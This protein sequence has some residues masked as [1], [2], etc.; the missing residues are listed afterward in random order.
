MTGHLLH[1]D[2][3][4]FTDAVY[5][6]EMTVQSLSLKRGATN[7]VKMRLVRCFQVLR[8]TMR[9]LARFYEETHIGSRDNGPFH[10]LPAPCVAPQ[11]GGP[12]VPFKGPNFSLKFKDMVFSNQGRAIF[13]GEI[14]VT[15]SDLAAPSRPLHDIPSTSS[16]PPPIRVSSST[17]SVQSVYVKFVDRYGVEVHEHLAKL[18]FAPKLWWFG[19]VVGGA[20]MVVMDEV[21]GRTV[22][23]YLDDKDTLLEKDLIGLDV[24]LGHLRSGH[25]VHGDLRPPN[26]VMRV[27]DDG[28]TTAVLI[29]FDWAG[30][31]GKV[32]YPRGRLNRKV[33]WPLPVDKMPGAL[34]LY[35]HDDSMRATLLPKP[36]DMQSPSSSKRAH[37]SRKRTLTQPQREDHGA[38]TR[39]SARLPRDSSA[40]SVAAKRL[41]PN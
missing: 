34:I 18:G 29:D 6:T 40:L 8:N 36:S 24:A 39:R 20:F 15:K 23:D 14:T 13:K 10:L 30:K 37:M 25:F 26:V 11:A 9:K 3:A 1:L 38:T 22:Q 35:E 33:K 41:K 12:C 31:A 19:E 27:N 28:T 16:A 7:A 4:I 5:C 32:R 21:K 2:A 17:P